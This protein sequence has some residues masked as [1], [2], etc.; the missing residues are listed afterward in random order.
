MSPI[1]HTSKPLSAPVVKTEKIIQAG[2]RMR[3][4]DLNVRVGGS[5]THLHAG[6]FKISDLVYLSRNVH[7]IP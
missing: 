2:N 4:R 6:L 3:I 7:I 5:A 1:Q